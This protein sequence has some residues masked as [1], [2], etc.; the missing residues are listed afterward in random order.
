[1]PFPTGV[2]KPV[3]VAR[4]LVAQASSSDVTDS[5]LNDLEAFANGTL[6]NTIR[7]L[8][9]LSKQAEGMFCEL[10]REAHSL[11][12]RVHTLQ[13]RLDRLSTSTKQLHSDEEKGN[14]SIFY[15]NIIRLES[16]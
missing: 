3:L 7:Q 8:S 14:Y 4:N 5:K 10:I 6:A 15:R 1:M 16:G 12:A 11:T 2:V 9:S 13:I